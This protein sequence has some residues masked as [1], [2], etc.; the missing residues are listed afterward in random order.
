MNFCIICISIHFLCAIL[1]CLTSI[2]QN[3]SSYLEYLQMYMNMY[4]GVYI[5]IFFLPCAENITTVEKNRYRLN[6]GGKT[7]IHGDLVHF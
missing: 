5:N 3:R 1:A 4:V 7:S 6:D 2:H